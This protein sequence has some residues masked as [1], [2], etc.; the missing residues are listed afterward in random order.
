MKIFNGCSQYVAANTASKVLHEG[1]GKIHAIVLTAA[2]AT[3]ESLT[4]YD[5]NAASGNVLLKLYVTLNAPV[6]M[7]FDRMLPLSFTAGLT[8]VTSVNASAF[9][10]TEF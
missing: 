2:V 1:G 3:V 8:A 6:V 10:I 9:V 7:H 5:N 4:L